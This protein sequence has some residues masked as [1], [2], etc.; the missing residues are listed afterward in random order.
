MVNQSKY[1]IVIV[2]PTAVGKTSLSIELAQK[3]HAEIIS[4]DSRQFYKELEIGTAKP[5]KEEI[6]KVP[7]HF[8]NNLSIADDYTVMNFEKEALLKINKLHENND[9]VIMTGGSGL[10]YKSIVD[11]FDEIPNVDPKFRKKLIDELESKGIENLQNELKEKDFEHYS[12]MDIQNS[13]RLIRALEICRSTGNPYSFYRTGKRKQR[14]F[15]IIKI[16][17]EME[18][19]KLFTRID[20]RMD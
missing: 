10:F 11:G 15:K 6:E 9:F 16:G 1:L 13:Q 3:I 14:P 7:H 4:C 18:S 8:V 17:L 2:G 20:Y 12:R 19:E 5:S